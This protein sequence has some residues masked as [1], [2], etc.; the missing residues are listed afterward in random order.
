VT[1]RSLGHD[2]VVLTH[3]DGARLCNSLACVRAGRPAEVVVTYGIL[4]DPGASLHAS[5]AL[6]RECGGRSYPLCGACW[7]QSRQVVVKYRP[8]LLVIDATGPAAIES[9]EG[10]A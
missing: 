10:R 2:Q 8:A 1:A 4:N 7:K 9:C 3:P 5:G 6:W